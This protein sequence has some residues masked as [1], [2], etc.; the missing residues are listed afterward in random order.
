LFLSSRPLGT[1]ITL[2]V[3]HDALERDRVPLRV[4]H[5]RDGL[6]RGDRAVEGVVRARCG[7]LAA[8]RRA[9][10]GNERVLANANVEGIFTRTRGLGSI[11]F[12]AC[13]IAR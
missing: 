8:D 2:D 6:T 5:R 4:P 12:I 9:R 3:R 10:V 1:I 11:V 13:V 7:I